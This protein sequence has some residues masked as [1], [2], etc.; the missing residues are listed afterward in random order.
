MVMCGMSQAKVTSLEG[1]EN[2]RITYSVMGEQTLPA[3]TCLPP[4]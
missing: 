2:Q 1:T 4:D 3:V